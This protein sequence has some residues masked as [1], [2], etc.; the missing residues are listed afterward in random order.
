MEKQEVDPIGQPIAVNHGV[1]IAMW[2]SH[3]EL[4]RSEVATARLE[5][6]KNGVADKDGT[7]FG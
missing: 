1:N 7:K 2:P 6:G 5:C 4:I 3:A